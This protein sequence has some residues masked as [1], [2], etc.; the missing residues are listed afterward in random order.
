[1]IKVALLGAGNPHSLGHL[2]TLQHLPEVEGVYLWDPDQEALDT[3][4]K[5]QPAKVQKSSTDLDSILAIKDTLLALVSHRNDQ[6]PEICLRAIGAGKHVLCEKPL[7]RTARDVEPI[8]AAA[9]KAGLK[10]GVCY[11][12]RAH[13][14]VVEARRLVSQGC[15]GPLMSTEAR[16]ES[17]QIRV[18]INPKPWLFSRQYAGGGVLS[19]VGCHYIDLMRFVTGDEIVSVSA[20]VAT[21]GGMNVDVEDVATLVFRFRSGAIGSF[22]AG[23]VLPFDS[24]GPDAMPGYDTHMAFNGLAGRIYWNPTSIPQRLHA[25]STLEAWKGAPIREITLPLATSPAYG[26]VFGEEYVRAFIH[27]AQGQGTAPATGR[28][29]LQIARIIDAAYE[30]SQTGRRVDVKP[31]AD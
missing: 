16:Y 17:T 11:Q 22:K 15:I 29:A 30:S 13:P 20:E 2:R 28:D 3:L 31:P 26:G 23:Y 7:G 19:W 9:D 18:K 10:L 5:A 25:E 6:T 27:A 8:V 24:G 4:Q 14:A 12:N 1:M 21:R